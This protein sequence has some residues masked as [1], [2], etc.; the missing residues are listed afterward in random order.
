MNANFTQA[1]GSVTATA[2]L[3]VRQGS[4]DRGASI[5]M[6]VEPGKRLNVLGFGKGESVSGNAD[7]F[8]GEDNTFFWSGGCSAFQPPVPIPAPVSG[9]APLSVNRRANGTILPLGF[10]DLKGV[11]GEFPY[12]EATHG[13][14]NLTG[15]WEAG[16]IVWMATPFLAAIGHPQLQV[17]TKAVNS[18]QRVFS[19]IA[20]AGLMGLFITCAG[21]FVPRHINHDPSKGLSSHSWGVTVDFNDKWNGYGSIPAQVGEYGSLR[22]VV[23]IFEAEGFA[24]G[25]NFTHP[26][27]DGMHFELA[28][29]DL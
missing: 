28:R 12:T 11:F 3:N 19:A 17:H 5:V 13:N 8:S 14:I 18:Y 27:E 6:K 23:P 26:R 7:W 25:G 21:T 10:A 16:N 29:L 9:A 22:Q 2:R 24:W 4:P 20:D 1:N 15:S